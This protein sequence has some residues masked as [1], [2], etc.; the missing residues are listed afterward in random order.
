M[1]SIHVLVIDRVD[2]PALA[3]GQPSSSEVVSGPAEAI[4]LGRSLA[5]RVERVHFAG[6]A[7]GRAALISGLLG[8]SE[9]RRTPCLVD[10]GA[11]SL[12]EWEEALRVGVRELRTL[13]VLGA[14]L[15]LPRVGVHVGFG[16]TVSLP[17]LLDGLESGSVSA[18]SLIQRLG[19]MLKGGG[20][21]EVRWQQD[22][23]VQ[24]GDRADWSG[25]AA[26]AL[27]SAESLADRVPIRIP[28]L[29]R[30][31][32]TQVLTLSSG[33]RFKPWDGVRLTPV[34]A[35]LRLRVTGEWSVDSWYQGVLDQAELLLVPGGKLAFGR[36]VGRQR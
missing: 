13:K 35:G 18:S 23:A 19:A 5:D 34:A 26:G 6:G 7:S 36:S 30:S 10:H 20:E 12:F 33:T 2:S 16:A 24:S 25:A 9:G 28:G 29:T 4:A 31:A 1:N 3:A 22:P 11:T 27:V 14:G 8:A 15:A 17:L 32:G 21:S